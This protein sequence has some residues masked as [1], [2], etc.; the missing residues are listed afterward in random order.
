MSILTGGL[1]MLKTFQNSINIYFKN[2]VVN[3]S[4]KKMMIQIQ[5]TTSPFKSEMQQ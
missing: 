4:K 5:T 3:I 2:Q 1:S